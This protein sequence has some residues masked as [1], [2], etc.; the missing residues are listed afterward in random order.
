M[1]LLALTAIEVLNL[2]AGAEQRQQ[3]L[4]AQYVYEEHQEN[5]R[6]DPY[7][8]RIESSLRTKTFEVLLI[9]GQRYR[10]LIARNGTPLT[11][12]EQWEVEQDMQRAATTPPAPATSLRDLAQTHQLSLDENTLVASSDSKSHQFTFH[13]VTHAIERQVT[14]SPNTRMT[15]DYI[16]LPG[17]VSLPKRIEVDFKVSDIH[18]LQVSTFSQHRKIERND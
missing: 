9:Q 4:R 2:I 14:T 7:G 5:W 18:G 15:L 3:D 12:A 8:R 17:G 16:Q 11:L 1:L 6:L 13:P 10:K